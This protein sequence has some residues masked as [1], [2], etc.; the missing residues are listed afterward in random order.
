MAEVIETVTEAPETDLKEVFY[1]WGNFKKRENC[2]YLYDND[3]LT[4]KEFIELAK[5]H[6]IKI[7]L[8]LF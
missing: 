4:D 2:L 6:K 3:C 8:N 1:G 7:Q 5:K